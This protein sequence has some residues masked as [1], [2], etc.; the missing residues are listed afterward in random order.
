MVV[1]THSAEETFE[2]GYKMGQKA[3]SGD[4][5][6]LEGD[7]G[8]GKTVFAQGFAKGLGIRENINSPT[9]TIVQI[10]EGGRLPLYH[11]DVYRITDIEEIYEIGFEEYF[12]GNGVCLIEWASIVHQVIPQSAVIIK[13]HKSLSADFDYRK[14]EI[15]GFMNMGEENE[16]DIGD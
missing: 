5:V 2:L 6:C 15:T 3:S 8:A 4:I 7:L 9:F 1:E 14:I 13:I 16:N 12:F 11:F 10:Y